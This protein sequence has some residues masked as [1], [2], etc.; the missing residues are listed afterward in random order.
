MTPTLT[1]LDDVEIFEKECAEFST[2]SDGKPPP[3]VEWYHGHAKLK[4]SKLISITTKD[5]THNLVL[6]DC[7]LHDTG[8]V[9]AVATNKAGS[10]TVESNL[11]IRGEAM[12]TKICY[13]RVK[14]IFAVTDTLIKDFFG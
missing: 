10:C 3:T 7:K 2:S 8:T 12:G 9:T 14:Q 5:N 11:N 1:E 4:H 13:Y 6:K